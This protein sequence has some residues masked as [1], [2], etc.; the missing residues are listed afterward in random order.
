MGRNVREGKEQNLNFNIIL[1]IVIPRVHSAGAIRTRTP[2]SARPA[3]PSKTRAPKPARSKA[4]T[5][6][7]LDQELDVFMA[8]DQGAASNGV[9][10]LEVAA[11]DVEMV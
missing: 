11:E 2:R 6:E 8:D 7:Q 9:G 3:P 1:L 4:P 5:A 10:K